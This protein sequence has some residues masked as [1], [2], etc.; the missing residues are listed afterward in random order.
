[1]MPMFLA[2]APGAWRCHAQ[3]G[4]TRGGPL[5]L[6]STRP[7]QDLFVLSPEPKR[8]Y[9]RQTESNGPG[10]VQVV[11]ESRDLAPAG[12]IRL[13]S[14]RRPLFQEGGS[15]P[16]RLSFLRQ[17]RGRDPHPGRSGPPT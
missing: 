7:A 5:P 9:R 14:P 10:P 13:Q 16:S 8:A 11:Q 2:W 6:P 1:M 12:P 3:T 4:D 17:L 15:A